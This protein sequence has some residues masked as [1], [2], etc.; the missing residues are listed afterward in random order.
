MD[1]VI[2]GK[3][4]VD[5]I[6]TVVMEDIGVRCRDIRKAEKN[7]KN[8][9]AALKRFVRAMTAYTAYSGRRSASECFCDR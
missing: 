3:L 8:T 2:V 5:L 9:L 4:L 6:T 1:I 7:A